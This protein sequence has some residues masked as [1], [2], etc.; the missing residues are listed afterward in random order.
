MEKEAKDKVKI[1]LSDLLKAHPDGLTIKE[2]MDKTGLA[3]HTILARL[4]NLQ[5][6]DKISV[7]Q[8]NMAKLHRWK[9]ENEPLKEKKPDDF[10]VSEIKEEHIKKAPPKEKTEKISGDNSK[11]EVEESTEIDMEALKAE[12]KGELKK[13]N[14]NKKQSQVLEQREPIENSITPN[15]LT[16]K[17]KEK[18]KSSGKHYVKTGIEGFY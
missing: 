6:A 4:H 7:R 8:I 15:D 10:Q 16:P 14:I 11:P 13:I 3:R 2:M 1:K 17:G 5:G 9:H 18:G 12:I